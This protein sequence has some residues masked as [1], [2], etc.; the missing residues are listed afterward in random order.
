VNASEAAQIAEAE[1]LLT[2]VLRHRP[3]SVSVTLDPEGWASIRD[4]VAGAP[5]DAGLT[6]ATLLEAVRLSPRHR[7]E[8]SNDGTRVRAKQGHSMPVNL[9]LVPRDPPRFLLHGTSRAACEAIREHGLIPGFRNHVHLTASRDVA[10]EVARRHGVPCVIYV[11]A[12]AM[13]ARGY[14]FFRSSN[15]VW[16]VERVPPNFIQFDRDQQEAN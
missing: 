15:D 4:I 6:E 13:H 7:F 16:L 10:E 8:L 5:A 11:D 12:K 1:K 2:I 9:G 14:A 3:Q